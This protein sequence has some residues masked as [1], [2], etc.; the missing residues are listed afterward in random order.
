[1]I[2]E[3]V[4]SHARFQNLAL[5]TWIV[6]IV[7]KS[8]QREHKDRWKVPDIRSFA[9]SLMASTFLIFRKIGPIRDMFRNEIAGARFKIHNRDVNRI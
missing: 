1:M 3:P 4:L 6:H 9:C 8:N 2:G 5:G 7:A